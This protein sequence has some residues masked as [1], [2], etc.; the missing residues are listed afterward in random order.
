MKDALVGDMVHLSEM[1]LHLVFRTAAEA[2]MRRYPL[3]IAASEACE[4]MV[5][6][7]EF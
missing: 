2:L 4:A 1:F 7:L 3:R 6:Q 5:V